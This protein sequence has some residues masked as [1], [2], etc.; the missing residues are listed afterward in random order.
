MDEPKI[1]FAFYLFCN[2][3]DSLLDFLYKPLN[4]CSSMSKIELSILIT[5]ESPRVGLI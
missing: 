2:D 1:F 4:D 5:S 3:A